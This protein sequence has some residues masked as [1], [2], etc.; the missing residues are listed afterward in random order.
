M[1]NRHVT[2]SGKTTA[3]IT[4]INCE[5]VDL[6]KHLYIYIY[7]YIFPG[8]HGK[9]REEMWKDKGIEPVAVLGHSVGRLSIFAH[10]LCELFIW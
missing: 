7:R 3:H 8:Q 1:S 4:L 5:V 2:Q 10:F 9:P 6:G